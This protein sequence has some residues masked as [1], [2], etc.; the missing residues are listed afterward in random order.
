MKQTIKIKQQLLKALEN[1][2][3]I[4]DFK[5][6]DIKENR[7]SDKGTEHSMQPLT[8]NIRRI[9]RSWKQETNT[10]RQIQLVRG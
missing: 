6:R 7:I 8:F 3:G 1:N 5:G 2:Q 9:L 4:Q 10:L